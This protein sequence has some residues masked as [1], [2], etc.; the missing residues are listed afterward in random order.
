MS[1]G[2]ILGVLMFNI[3]N[4]FPIYFAVSKSLNLCVQDS[5]CFCC[6]PRYCVY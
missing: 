6:N 1:D 4:Y 3:Q 2:L 5:F